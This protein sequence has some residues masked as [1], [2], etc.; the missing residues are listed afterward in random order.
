M[1][2]IRQG[3]V[4]L[5]QVKIIPKNLTDVKI[6]NNKIVLA[7]GEATGHAHTIKKTPDNALVFDKTNNKLYLI[8]KKAAV[9]EHQEHKKIN[10]PIGNYEVIRQREYRPERI[11]N[12][13]D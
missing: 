13:A 1:I 2:Q 7:E 3:D 8:L 9:L 12:V 10:L 4:L 6:E 11:V 5:K